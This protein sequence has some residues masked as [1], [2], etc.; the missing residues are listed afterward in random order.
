MWVTS[1][2]VPKPGFKSSVVYNNDK[3]ISSEFRDAYH[4]SCNTKV[5]GQFVVKT[6][7]INRLKSL[8]DSKMIC[9]LKVQKSI[10]IIPYR[11]PISGTAECFVALVFNSE[12]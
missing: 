1:L 10:L 8:I 5:S 6:K 11:S 2:Y 3:G 12:S 7:K 9:T 4:R